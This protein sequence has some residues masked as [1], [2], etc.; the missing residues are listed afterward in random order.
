MDNWIIN[1]DGSVHQ[2]SD[3][4][5]YIDCMSRMNPAVLIPDGGLHVGYDS[6]KD[7]SGVDVT[8]STVFLGINHQ[9]R[10]GGRPILFESM[11]FDGERAGWDRRYSTYQE[12]LEGHKHAIR[13]A[14]GEI[15]EDDE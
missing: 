9:F 5:S 4:D 7:D 1:R 3:Y 6:F 2:E 13:V 10:E 8:V 15:S 12:A 14:K 11:I